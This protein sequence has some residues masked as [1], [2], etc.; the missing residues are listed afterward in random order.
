MFT[1]TFIIFFKKLTLLCRMVGVDDEGGQMMVDNGY[2]DSEDERRWMNDDLFIFFLLR[3][4]CEHIT[5][6]R[7]RNYRRSLKTSANRPFLDTIKKNIDISR[8]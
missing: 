1:F 8:N 3:A 5:T 6:N 2:T 4:L 7:F